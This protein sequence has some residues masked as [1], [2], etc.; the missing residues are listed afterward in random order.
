M[1]LILPIILFAIL[2]GC[3]EVEASSND[4]D[5]HELLV[6]FSLAPVTFTNSRRCTVD[7]GLWLNPYTGQFFSLASDLDVEHIV[8]LSWAHEHGGANWTVKLKRQFAEDPENL[9]LVDGGRNQSKGDKGPD[10]WMPPY[11]PVRAI[12]VK[13][14]MAIMEKYGLKF[15]SEES[16]QIPALLEE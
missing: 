7:T 11:E 14:F 9:G 6:Q 8:P 13:R 10:E 2:S 3:L 16:T 1:R 5:R 4:Y 12:Y 15:S